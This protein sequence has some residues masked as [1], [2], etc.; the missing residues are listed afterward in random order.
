[1][2]RLLLGSTPDVDA[3]A[4][5]RQELRRAKARFER[6][7]NQARKERRASF[8]EAQKAGLTLREIGAEVG[9]HHT[10]VLQILRD[11]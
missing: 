3:K 5:A 9:M 2:P 4:K 1:M 11:E 6:K 10:R 7:A 8:E